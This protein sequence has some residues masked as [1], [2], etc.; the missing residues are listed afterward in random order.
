MYSTGQDQEPQ[1]DPN[2][3]ETQICIRTK[4]VRIRNDGRKHA[5]LRKTR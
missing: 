2:D 3:L 4:A 1:P 5:I